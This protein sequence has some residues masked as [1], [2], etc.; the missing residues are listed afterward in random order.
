MLLLAS[1]DGSI[2]GS[3]DE[4]SLRSDTDGAPEVLFLTSLDVAG[5]EVGYGDV[6]LRLDFLALNILVLL[7]I[8]VMRGCQ[9][10]S[11]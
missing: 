2:W 5:L 7:T 11:F 9:R 8:N 3:S 10:K 1:A 6:D 4:C